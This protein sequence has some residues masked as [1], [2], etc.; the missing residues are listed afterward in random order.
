MKVTDMTQTQKKIAWVVVG[1]S[2][3][4][5]LLFFPA[6]NTAAKTPSMF[7][8]T[9]VDEPVTYTYVV[10]MLNA[11]A[12]FKSIFTRWV[13]YGDYHYG[14]LFYLLSALVLLPVRLIYGGNFTVSQLQ[15]NIFLLRQFISVLPMILS[16]VLMVY[17]VTKFKSWWKTIAW[18]TTTCALATTFTSP[19]QPVASPLASSWPGCSL[20]R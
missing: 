7:A 16:I 9:S 3:V 14:W 2:L 19:R 13:L 1:I 20:P 4:Y 12:N 8:A 15:L 17:L 6:N 18:N 10:R 11:D 5:F